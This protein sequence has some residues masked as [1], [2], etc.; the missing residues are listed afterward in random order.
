M[1]DAETILLK[2]FAISGFRS[3]GSEPQFFPSLRKV[4]LLIGRN[5]SGKSNVIRFLQKVV[6]KAL[7]RQRVQMIELDS[8][9]PQRP[10]P[11]LG[12]RDD[13]L[14][15]PDSLRLRPDHPLLNFSAQYAEDRNLARIANCLAAEYAR[16]RNEPNVWSFLDLESSKVDTEP[17]KAA[18]ASVSDPELSV[19]W[20]ALTGQRGGGRSA[21]WE[22][23]L[24]RLLSAPIHHLS[25]EVIPAVREIRKDRG[26]Q[27]S[28]DGSGLI[29]ELARLQN[30]ALD[31]QR[32][33]LKFD[34]FTR[35][36]QNVM[37]EKDLSVEIP[38]NRETILIKL[39]DK[40]LPVESL[41]TGL[42]EVIILAAATTTLTK[43]L[44]CIEEPELHLNPLLQRKLMRYLTYQTDN[45]YVI[46]THS[47]A[48]MDTPEAEIYHIRLVGGSS[49]VE[50]ATSTRQKSSVCEDLG[51]HP[52]DL[53]QANSIIWVEGPSDRIYLKYWITDCDPSLIEGIHYSIMFYGGRLASHLSAELDD[54][55]DINDFIALRRLNRRG[56]ILIDSDKPSPHAKINATKLRLAR[57]FGEGPGHAW[58]TAGREIE[59]YLPSNAIDRAIKSI[60]PNAARTSGDGQHDRVLAMTSRAATERTADKVRVA[61]FISVHEQPDLSR[62]DLHRQIQKLVSFI[63][64]SNP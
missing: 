46:S 52:S 64:A 22:P 16:A 4:T 3:F 51:Y 1:P 25:T 8:H 10:T 2:N 19:L 44:V 14:S 60:H 28:F 7:A 31:H 48:I 30:P 36:V 53:L 41:G 33:R 50:R 26:T 61:Q 27:A 58:I 42:H 59:N 11:L 38:H 37:N 21:H 23:E 17:W 56:V 6:P 63:R 35:F 49:V 29:D 57:E 39:P 34:S 40:T 20:A 13:D 55:K 15:S 24:L 12:W 32:D 43:Y 47:P 9:L 18:L 5:N 54:A 45:Q 62:L